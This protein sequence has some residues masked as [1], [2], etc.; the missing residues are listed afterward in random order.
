M[1]NYPQLDNARG[2][3]NMKEVYDAVMGGYW[4]NA[5]SRACWGGGRAPAIS[6]V[7]DYVTIS[8]AG[9]A[10]D[11][12][13]LTVAREAAQSAGSFTRAIW[14]G[15][16]LSPAQSDTVDYVVFSSTGNAAD[17]GNL[18][19]ARSGVAGGVSANSKRALCAAGGVDTP[20]NYNVIDY[21]TM[22]SVG[23]H[24]DF[25]DLT[26][27]S[28]GNAK[29]CSPTRA[30]FAGG[31][32]GEDDANLRDIIDFVEFATT[33]N[34]VDFGDLLAA[35]NYIAGTSSSTRAAFGGGGT[36]PHSN[37]I[38]YVDIASQGNATDY[39]DLSVTRG[40]TAGASSNSVKG[41]WGGGATPTMNETDACRIWSS[42]SHGRN[43]ISCTF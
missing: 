30:I 27:T 11:F 32:G 8:S 18:S 34:A 21:I 29:A 12:G 19:S 13:D 17:F 33:G 4:P 36:D 39:G 37:V 7:I 16:R 41:L 26:H 42:N 23:N 25:G 6:N 43:G 5:L 14:Q 28:R 15:G 38:Q 35:Q 24:V 22:A 31:L 3:W 40:F 2:V 20:A 10:A 9:N 1:A